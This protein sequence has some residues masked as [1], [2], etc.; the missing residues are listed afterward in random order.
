[1]KPCTTFLLLWLAVCFAGP[2]NGALAE[3]EIRINGEAP[4]AAVESAGKPDGLHLPTQKI[5]VRFVDADLTTAL[6]SL[7]RM[8]SQNILINPSVQGRIDAHIEN[9]PW[10]Q[11]FLGV[12][13]TYGLAYAM[14]GNLLRIMSFED[15]KKQVER[16]TLEREKEQTLPLVTQII[17]IEFA[18]PDQVAQAITPLL[19]KDKNGNVRGSVSI[20]VHTRSLIIQ[21]AE[22]NIKRVTSFVQELDR[23]TPQILIEAHIIET[24]K[25]T[26]RE[27]GVQWGWLLQDGN[28]IVTPG[29]IDGR[30]DSAT[31][32]RLYNAGPRGDNRGGIS[33]QG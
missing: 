28:D 22:D 5:S 4:V 30:V 14:E 3:G 18:N 25:D 32:Q 17:P 33:S 15:V 13:N 16:E 9:A 24:T 11:V 21:D 2:V 26:A 10:D 27:L 20:D 1:M 8:A 23:S 7:G 31:G 12:V 19:T 29:G 6:R